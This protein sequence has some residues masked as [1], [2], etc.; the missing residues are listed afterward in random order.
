MQDLVLIVKL[1]KDLFEGAIVGFS[2]NVHKLA[3]KLYQASMNNS[4]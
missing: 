1:N 2:N 4:N 3:Y